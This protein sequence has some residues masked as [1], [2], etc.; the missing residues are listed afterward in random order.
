VCCTTDLTANYEI[1][2]EGQSLELNCSLNCSPT[3]DSGCHGFDSSRMYFV[4]NNGTRQTID[5]QYYRTDGPRTLLLVYPNIS[6]KDA[7]YY[8]CWHMNAAAGPEW[9]GTILIEVGSKENIT[10][11][12]CSLLRQ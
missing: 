1:I 9:Q 12:L 7:G 6:M 10:L 4:V 5:R 11:S 2:S 3:A 8:E